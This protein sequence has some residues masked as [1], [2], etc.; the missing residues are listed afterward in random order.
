MKAGELSVPVVVT[1]SGGPPTPLVTVIDSPS[2]AET[3]LAL[4][5]HGTV[6][7]AGEHWETVT[8]GGL[9]AWAGGVKPIDPT[10]SAPALRATKP[11][12][13]MSSLPT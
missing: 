11:R 13:R 12:L 10:T 6:L 3:A 7:F 9:T 4:R 8:A 5:T 2:A 1:V